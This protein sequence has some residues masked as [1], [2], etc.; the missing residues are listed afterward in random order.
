MCFFP[1]N[2]LIQSLALELMILVWW[3]QA[4]ITPFKQQHCP[5][6]SSATNVIPKLSSRKIEKLVGG[7]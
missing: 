7:I 5:C 2:G 3:R 1:M 6:A 4:Q